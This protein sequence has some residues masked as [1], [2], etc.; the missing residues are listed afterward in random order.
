M[1]IFS[2]NDNRMMPVLSCTAGREPAPCGIYLHDNDALCSFVSSPYDQGW[3][4]TGAVIMKQYCRTRRLVMKQKS[5][6]VVIFLC[7]FCLFAPGAQVFAM[8]EPL[9]HIKSMVTSQNVV[10]REPVG[11]TETF[12]PGT[13]RVYCFLEALNIEEDTEVTMVWYHND[14][15]TARVTLPLAK[16][17]RW[18]TYASKDVAGQPGAW[19]VDLLESSG[20]VLNTLPF[21]VE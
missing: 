5:W 18:R 2:Q 14:R 20:I 12:P 6:S 4:K 15:E 9:F 1:I 3:K 13:E 17:P 10:D 8:D 7:F 21:T 11:V 16:G 19:S